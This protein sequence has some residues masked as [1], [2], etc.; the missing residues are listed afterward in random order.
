MTDETTQVAVV[1]VDLSAPENQNPK[2][3]LEDTEKIKVTRVKLSKFM[4]RLLE[5]PDDML[6]KGLYF[7]ALGIQ[8]ATGQFI[9]PDPAALK[10]KA[11]QDKSVANKI[12][13]KQK[14]KARQAEN[15]QKGK[16]EDVPES[17]SRIF[18]KASEAD[19][20]A[21]DFNFCLG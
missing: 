21:N 17:I 14:R 5:F 3:R 1:E 7:M 18:H 8:L 20:I 11:E 2:Q 12:A 16:N 19:W 4:E 15:R 9:G 13:K 6:A 10:R